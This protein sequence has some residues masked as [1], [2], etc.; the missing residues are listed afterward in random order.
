MAERMT[1]PMAEGMAKAIAA[2]DAFLHAWK[3]EDWGAM[4]LATQQTWTSERRDALEFL[5]ARFSPMRLGSWEIEEI[6]QSEGL[7]KGVATDAT[8]AVHF[9]NMRDVT[10]T[11][12][13]I[14]EIGPYKPRPD[15]AWGVNPISWR[16][17]N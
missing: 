5:K 4:F 15:G 3:S 7:A 13:L 6:V 10:Y 1:E 8:V 14:C 2:L 12:R 9:L 16:V 11:V 17:V